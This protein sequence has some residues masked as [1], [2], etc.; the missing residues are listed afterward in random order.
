MIRVGIAGIGFMGWIHWLAYQKV[1][2]IQ[3]AAIHSR[4]SKKLRGDWREIQGNFGPPGEQVDL[5]QLATYECYEDLLRD[6]NID[7]IDITLPAA[8]HAD[9]AIKALR[10]GKHVFCEKP[11]ALTVSECRRIS[12]E[13]SASGR[14]LMVGH[15]L[16][17]TS[18]ICL[19]SQNCK[20]RQVWQ[21]PGREFQASYF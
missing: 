3:V 12:R 20:E 15:V 1:P 11:L 14:Q 18:R 8:M 5:S 17:F 9:T 21:A 6:P 10:A 19:G 16:P 13:A 7:L 4:N 2:G